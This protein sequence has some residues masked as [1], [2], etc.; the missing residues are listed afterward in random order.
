VFNRQMKKMDCI[1]VL[2]KLSPYQ[3][4]EV[5]DRERIL[6]EAHLSNCDSCSR[7][8]DELERI[9]GNLAAV[10]EMDPPVNFDASVMSMVREHREKEYSGKLSLAYAMVFGLFLLFGIVVNP[11][12]PPQVREPDIRPE[13]FSVLLEGQKFSPGDQSHKVITRLAGGNHEKRDR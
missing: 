12:P 3:D 13:L 10:R 1:K 6:I 5:N 4:G 8:R 2:R 7:E 9:T 11:F